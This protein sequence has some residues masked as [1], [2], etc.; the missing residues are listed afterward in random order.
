MSQAAGRSFL[1]VLGPVLGFHVRF[2]SGWWRG[3]LPGVPGAAPAS[4]RPGCVSFR[5]AGAAGAGQLGAGRVPKPH[6]LRRADAVG[7]DG[8]VVP[9]DRVDVLRVV[10]AGNPG[11]PAQRDICAG[12]GV[13]PSGFLL[14]GGHVLLVPARRLHPPGD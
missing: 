3:V 10:A 4:T 1:F 13:L 12:D 6:G 9:L 11:D 14:V 5:V 7:L 2:G 8:G